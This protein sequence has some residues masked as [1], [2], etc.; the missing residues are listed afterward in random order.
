MVKVSD[1]N[2]VGYVSIAVLILML[3]VASRQFAIGLDSA[4]PY[5]VLVNQSMDLFGMAV[6][7]ILFISGVQFFC[8]GILGQ[9][10]AKTYME[11]KNR[12]IYIKNEKNCF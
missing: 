9:Y 2:L 12:P 8:T 5:Y 3:L 7:I 4:H 11:V 10:L 6:C 1:W